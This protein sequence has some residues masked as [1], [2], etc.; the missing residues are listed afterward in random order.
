MKILFSA[1]DAG[2]MDALTPVINKIKDNKKYIL[3]VFLGGPAKKIAKS[4]KIKFINCEK[5]TIK[6]IE[7]LIKKFKPDVICTGTSSGKTIEKIIWRI[8]KKEDIPTVAVVDFWINYN[9]QFSF[10]NKEKINKKNLPDLICLM[11]DLGK[12]EMIKEGFPKEILKI[13]GNPHFEN[14][15]KFSKVNQKRKK[16]TYIDQHFSELIPKGIHDEIGFREQQVFDDFI[17]SLSENDWDGEVVIKFHPG[18]K[19]KNRYDATIKKSKIKIR[20]AKPKEKLDTLLEQSE[21]VAGMTSMALFEAALGGKF[22]VSYQPHQK[23]KIDPLISNRLGLS[24][25]AYSYKK[26]KNVITKAIKGKY[27]DKNI[28]TIREKYTKIHATENVL[29]Q[30]KNISKK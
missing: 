10:S 1:Y 19:T 14:F 21:F 27:N 16:I 11:D 8:A 13:T 28:K 30:I 2:G 15:K 6:E 20:K 7:D 26:L 9:L 24:H 5:K 4:E 12:K 29:H 22:V 23:K 17:K 25:F 18:S 3:K